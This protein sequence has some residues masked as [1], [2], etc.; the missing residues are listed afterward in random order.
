MCTIKNLKGQ[1]IRTIPHSN[2]LCEIATAKHSTT[3]KI[4]NT[5]SV[6][7]SGTEAHKKFGHIAFLT[8]KYA[9]SNGLITGIELDPN[10]KP[11]FCE[12]CTKAKLAWQPFPR[13]SET[14]AER[15]GEQVHWDLWGPASVKSLNGNY[16]VA[17]QIDNATRQTKLHFQ[18]K[19]SQTPLYKKDEAYIETQSGNWVKICC[20]DKGREF[21][22]NQLSITRIQ[23]IQSESSLYMIP[24]CRME[25]SREECKPGPNK[26]APSYCHLAYPVFCGKKQ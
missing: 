2:R 19:K 3:S 11:N 21:L 12:A 8:T 14:R 6:K 15:F 22:S 24:L 10:S 25:F 1:T 20:S 4:A 23:R 9:I 5:T 17:A 26:P 18:A 16:Y 13:E 7:M